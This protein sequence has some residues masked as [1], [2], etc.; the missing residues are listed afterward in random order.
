MW[1]VTG[2][3]YLAG[4]D[5]GPVDQPHLDL[6]AA[7]VDEVVGAS[8]AC[9]VQQ[10]AT[11]LPPTHRLLS[12]QILPGIIDTTVIS[13]LCGEG[14]DS[15]ITVQVEEGSVLLPPPQVQHGTDLTPGQEGSLRYRQKW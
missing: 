9:Q 4:E 8:H 15:E 11:L 1:H 13:V 2:A 12:V 14:W 5:G 7:R 10:F 6:P 3:P